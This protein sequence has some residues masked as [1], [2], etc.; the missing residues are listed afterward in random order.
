[1]KAAFIKYGP[2]FLA[3]TGVLFNLNVRRSTRSMKPERAQPEPYVTSA[4]W[5]TSDS[6]TIYPHTRANPIW[7][8]LEVRVMVRLC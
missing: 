5:Q 3:N 7:K 4:L 1:M 8:P 2:Q 6:N